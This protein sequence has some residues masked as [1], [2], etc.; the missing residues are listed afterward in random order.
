MHI[1]LQEQLAAE[2][3]I[4]QAAMVEFM[5]TVLY[6]N[7]SQIAQKAVAALDIGNGPT[8]TELV[9]IA[10]A[11][12]R[13]EQVSNRALALMSRIANQHAEFHAGV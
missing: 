3:A 2:S 12:A 10:I 13:G 6:G 5:R 9:D 11:A 8:T 4:K 1:T 7:D